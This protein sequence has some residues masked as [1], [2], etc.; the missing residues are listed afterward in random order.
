M[1]YPIECVCGKTAQVPN[2]GSLATIEATTSFTPYARNDC[3]VRWI[4]PACQERAEAAYQILF[5]IFGA[6][7]PTASVGAHI[8]KLAKKDA[9]T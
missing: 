1:P 7:V 4:C 6:D 3:G 2:T 8:R 5:D 9:A